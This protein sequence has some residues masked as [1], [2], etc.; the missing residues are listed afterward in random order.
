MIDVFFQVR[1]NQR[2]RLEPDDARFRIGMFEVEHRHADVAPAIE[3]QRVKLPCLE[4]INVAYKDVLAQYMEIR[5]V[6]DAHG[7]PEA[8]QP[9][10]G[11]ALAQF[12]VQTPDGTGDEV[13][14][15]G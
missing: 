10:A 13:R 15:G 14:G 2:I 8:A 6:I 3:N 9:R 5:G 11:L 7:V 1:E 4:M 12:A